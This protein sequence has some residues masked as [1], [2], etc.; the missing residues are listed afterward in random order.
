MGGPRTVVLVALL[1]GLAVGPTGL[2]A[3][4]SNV[5]L[6]ITVVDADGDTVPNAE[7]T[8]TWDGG[9]ATETTRANGQALIDVPRGADVSIAVEHETYMRNEPFEIT[10][11]S[12]GEVE[13][14]VGLEGF[15]A[16]SVTDEDGPV[17]GATVRFQDGGL[18]AADVRTGSNGVAESGPLEHGS[19]AL[20]VFK[21]GYFEHRETVT[22]GNASEFDVTLERGTVPVSFTVVDDH[23]EE[24]RPVPNATIR[25]EP[26]GTTLRTLSGGEVETSLPV[27][28]QYEITVTKDRY[29]SVTKTLRV[30]ESG[31]EVSAR[32]SREPVVTLRSLNEQVVVGETTQV[33]VTDAYGDPIQG[34]TVS[35][36]GETV[37]ETDAEGTLAVPI[38]E[39][40]ETTIRASYEGQ[41]DEVRVTGY[42]PGGTPTATD[43]PE[44]DGGF[45]PGPGVVGALVAVAL[46]VGLLARRR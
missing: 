21:P 20:I 22:V 9:S 7:L 11:A 1:V 26:L 29:V 32:I 10:D 34:A 43:T 24:P 13:I 36:G 4:Q 38:E 8:A 28:T 16:V 39:A 14:P 15:A 45:G 25:I 33:T 12:E 17:R 2:A 5:T 3:A 35:V 6:T 46:A 31:R 27:N 19:Y 42:Q 44:T 41:S 40:G 30:S 37:G 18:T 23:F